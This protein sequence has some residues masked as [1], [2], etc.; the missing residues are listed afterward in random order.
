MADRVPVSLSHSARLRAAVER[1]GASSLASRAAAL[2]ATGDE[3]AEFLRYLGGRAYSPDLD[4]YW[5]QSWGARALEY[6]WVDSAAPAV[7]GGLSHRHW[8][9]RMVCARVCA[10]RSLGEP[11]RLAL[12]LGDSNWRVRDAAA[13]AL[14]GV[15]EFEHTAG[16]RSLM[17]GDSAPRVRG[18]AEGALV[19]MA[20]RLDRPLDDFLVG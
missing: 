10:V 3:D 19:A 2:L 9:V 17:N 4:P 8:R 5:F 16:L 15:G 18:R 12:L 6:Y 11:E 13:W 20:E 14:G 7:I 1:Y